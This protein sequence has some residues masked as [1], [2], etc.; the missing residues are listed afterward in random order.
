MR[1]SLAL[2]LFVCSFSASAQTP[3]LVK[4][5]NTTN[6]RDLKSSVPTEFA[7]AG[8]TVF[9]AASTDAY[10]S[11][12][13]ST[14][15][16][17]AGTKL[18][19]DIVPGTSSSSPGAFRTVN[20]VLLFSARDA[21][22][23][24]ELWT[25]DGTAA[26][27]HLFL[28]LNPG[29]SSAQAFFA[30]FNYKNGTFFTA[31]DGVNGRELWFTDG[32][33]AG[34][35][36]VKDINPGSA[37]SFPSSLT[38]FGGS[39]YFF[40]TGG[41]W[42]T[43]GTDAGTVKVASVSGRGLAAAGSQLFFDGFSRAAGVEPWVSD[44]T[45][46]GTHQIADILPGPNGS[47]DSIYPITYVPIGN[48]A[49][50]LAKDGVHGRELW[51]TDGTAAG[52]HMVHDFLPGPKGAWDFGVP[53]IKVLNGR[54]YFA[55]SDGAHG[56]ELWVSDGTESGTSRVLDSASGS[57]FSYPF[58]LTLSGAK[59][60]FWAGTDSLSGS[61]LW[62]SD[63]TAAGTHRLG[64]A[65]RLGPGNR[66]SGA[67]WP[68]DG[69]VY[70]N[71]STPLTGSEP[72]VS[73]GTDAGTRMIANLAPDGAPSSNPGALTRAGSVLVFYASDG[74]P[75]TN[76]AEATVWRTDGTP[77]GTFKL[78][79]KAKSGWT[80]TSFG[81]FALFKEPFDNSPVFI[82][83]G[84]VDGTGPATSFL[85]RF[86][87]P[88]VQTYWRFG[89]TL[90]AAAGGS[91]TFDTFLW[92]TTAALNAP[93]VNLGAKTPCG[94]IE[95]GWHS[96]VYAQALRGV[97][98]YGLRTTDGTPQGTYAVLPE[99]GDTASQSPDPMVNAGG[100]I[101]FS[102]QL[103]DETPKL[104]R[105]DGTFDGTVP[106]KEIPQG[107]F[108]LTAAGRRVFFV[109]NAGSFNS[110]DKTLWTSDGTAEGT[111][112]L[113][114]V[115]LQDARGALVAAG[116]RV[117]FAQYDN[118]T[119]YHLW[120]SDGTVE[121]TKL[122]RDLNRVF[123]SFTNIDGTLYFAGNDDAHGSELW[124]TDGTA[125]GTKLLADV[126]PG[127]ASS[128]PAEF[129][130][131]GDTLY[132]S[133]S[134]ES[135]G[136]E[137]WALP[138][139]DPALSIADARVAEGGSGTAAMRFTVTLTPAAKQSV[140]VDYATSDG[141]ARAGDD[142]DAASG[143]LIFAP[144]ETA[145]TIDVR[146]RGD[147]A[148]EG[149]ET[150]FVA[151]RSAHGARVVRSDAAGIIDDDD[152]SA[153]VSVA[154]KFSPASFSG[155]LDDVVVSNAGPRAAT[156][157]A[158]NITSTLSQSPCNCAPSQLA[159]GA[160][161]TLL[162]FSPRPSGSLSAS[163][164]ARE[165]DPQAAN[166]TATWTMNGDQTLG[167]DRAYLFTGGTA[168]GAAYTFRENP[169][170][171]LSDPSVLS[172]G[173][174]ERNAAN[175]FTTFKITALKPGTTTLS[176]NGQGTQ[177]LTVIVAEPGT[178][179]RFPGGVSIATD[180]S[181]TRL[182]RPITVT[183]S[184][185]GTSPYNGAAPTGTVTVTAGGTEVAHGIIDSTRAIRLPF[186]LRSLNAVPYTIA[187]SG[188]ANFAPQT[189]NGS[190]F[191]QKAQTT[192]TASL[193][194]VPGAAGTF[195]LNVD[196]AGSPVVPPAGTLSVMSGTTEIARVTLTAAG[197]VSTAKA[198]LSSLPAAPALTVSYP[199]DSLHLST[200]QQVR[201]VIPRT[202][203]VRH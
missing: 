50:F 117:L 189:V 145:K 45:E 103:R 108:S 153:D 77:A 82:T 150:F 203:A 72:W 54:A 51:V 9:F 26:G 133:A 95:P 92:K 202:R 38:I 55:A 180:F 194:A 7:K 86:D 34:T 97:Y 171:V 28:D 8:N 113:A 61:S 99:L 120:T 173:T 185:I 57:G 47:T 193:Q 104:W 6:S 13:W 182:D 151:L 160:S 115:K 152:A 83:D 140:T 175:G 3:V 70:F 19:A 111:V 114:N 22:H 96:M 15:G 78:I 27:T 87:S 37:G 31:D 101:F 132:F 75:V 52:T 68:V 154:V 32:T 90:F 107:V 187:Y 186:Y 65:D 91:G 147:A 17:S 30:S 121:G 119:G 14:D 196:A 2:L 199:G 137:L 172:V 125:E 198:T 94:M 191:G 59:L 42:K 16:T 11:E 135:V 62:V 134:E 169:A 64:A 109:T 112:A 74:T 63:G 110:P 142:Y 5:I 155:I 23:G 130:K 84:T 79:D 127:P 43:D 129:T 163:V 71:G 195:V 4:D 29:P 177:Q 161:Q 44:G 148:S 25:S 123:P 10:G 106:V 167:I 156:N 136:R 69:K 165:R 36:I 166:N 40:T 174:L 93:A 88:K 35:R 178:V 197:S 58:A 164:T 170:I 168:N 118:D 157:I 116:N 139:A 24:V 53:F 48:R 20:G 122:L 46:A 98:Y 73:D 105:S 66:R 124:T 162:R 158:T 188:D 60:F 179:P 128:N 183:V 80:F 176:I 201:V 146:V 12:L 49:L 18:V 138:L 89:D 39:V 76:S 102:M 100:T 144:G 143:T 81:P 85:S 190:V 200:A 41:L 126:N 181:V 131:I 192:L 1:T 21:N 33:A 67:I 141:T 184:T 149:N 56:D 159:P